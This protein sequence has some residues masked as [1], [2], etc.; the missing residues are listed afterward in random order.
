M[1][2]AISQEAF[3]INCYPSTRTKYN[4]DEFLQEGFL[5]YVEGTDFTCKPRCFM[6]YLRRKANERNMTCHAYIKDGN[7]CAHLQVESPSLQEL[8]DATASR[9]RD[10]ASSGYAL[11]EG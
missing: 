10:I 11:R 7:V 5:M 2:Q 3:L 6:Q 1:P 9:P 4:W 8:R